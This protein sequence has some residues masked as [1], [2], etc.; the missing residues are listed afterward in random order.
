MLKRKDS[1]DFCGILVVSDPKYVKHRESAAG[2]GI[3][4]AIQAMSGA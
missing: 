3:F 2:S 4:Y 1:P